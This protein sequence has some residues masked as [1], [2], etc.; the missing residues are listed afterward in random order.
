MSVPDGVDGL[1]FPCEC[2]S[3]RRGGY[4]DPWAAVTKHKL[5]PDGTKEYGIFDEEGGYARRATFT[6]DKQGVIRHIE[7]GKE[8]ID[9]TGAYQSCSALGD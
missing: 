8:A 2:V 5:L 3:S 7:Q 4:S 9:P 6:V 1:R